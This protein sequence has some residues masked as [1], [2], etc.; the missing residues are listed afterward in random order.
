MTEAVKGSG[1]GGSLVPGTYPA[2]EAMRPTLVGENWSVVAGHPRVS[3]VAAEIFSAGGNAVDAGVAAGIASNVIQVDMCNFGGIAP[4]LIRPAD[5]KDSFSVA[6]IGRWSRSASIEKLV[7]RYGGSLPL[8]G[9]P[10][11]VPGA[12]A[13]WLK[14]LERFGTMSFAEVAAPAIALAKDGFLLDKRSAQSLEITGRGYSGWPTSAAIYQPAGKP[15]A[16][17][18]RLRQPALADLLIRRIAATGPLTLA[19]YMAD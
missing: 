3:M 6:G 1:M 10:A 7:S 14:A 13:G 9:A 15:M 4:I 2:P 18:S 12:P 8:D 11:I 17:G 5:S 19:D 16:E